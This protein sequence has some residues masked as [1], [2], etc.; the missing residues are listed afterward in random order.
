[1]LPFSKREK[2]KSFFG[3]GGWKHDGARKAETMNVLL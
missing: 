2:E 3:G 1:M